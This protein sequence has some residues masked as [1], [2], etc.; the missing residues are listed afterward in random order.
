MNDDNSNAYIRKTISLAAYEIKSRLE[1]GDTAAARLRSLFED[2][3]F[4]LTSIREQATSLIKVLVRTLIDDCRGSIE[5][6]R[7]RV[8]E[9]TNVPPD[10]C[11]RGLSRSRLPA[12]DILVLASH[13]RCTV[14]VD[15]VYSLMGV[16]GVKF[17]AFHAEG[18][19]KALC[20]LLD[21]VVITSNDISVFN[22]AGKDLGSPIRGRSLYPSK[23]SAFSPKNTES[24]LTAKKNDEA[25][26]ASREERH[27]LQDTESRLTLLLRGTMEFVKVTPHKD[28]PV[29][30]I[31]SILG[32]IKVTK[33]IDLQPQLENLSRLLVYLKNTPH[34]EEYKPKTRSWDDGERNK[35]AVGE[36]KNVQSGGNIASRFGIKTP[37]IP[38]M[39][40][41]PQMPQFSAPKLK[42]GGFQSFYGKKNTSKEPEPAS[43]SSNAA[44]ITQPPATTVQEQK[45][46]ETLVGEV[47]AWISKKK[48]IKNVP[49]EFKALFKHLEAEHLDATP[50]GEEESKKIKPSHSDSTICPNP[51][52][53]T[54]SGIEGIFDIQRVIITMPHAEQLHHQVDSA[55]HESE[56]ISGDCTI[57]TG[58]STITVRFSCAAGD[59]RKQLNV[60]DVV[61]QALFDDEVEEGAQGSTQTEQ[62][63]TPGQESTSYYN[64]L[65]SISSGLVRQGS[66][67]TGAT[68]NEDV[69]KDVQ[70]EETQAHASGQ[71]EEQRRVT[72]MLDFVQETD[73]NFIVGE[74]VLARFTGAEGAKWFLCQL[75]L[76]ST[77]NYY[78][79][80]IATDEIDF[81]TVV[82]E[83]GLMGHW[84]N[85]MENKKSELCRVV[86]VFVHARDARRYADEVAGPEKEKKDG[87]A[88]NKTEEEEDSDNAESDPKER[89]M[90]FIK[91]GTHIGA[92]IVQT[93]TDKWGERLDGMLSDTILQKVQKDLRA[94]I[95]N[96]NENK[97]LLPAMFLSGV[98]VHMF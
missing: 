55:V 21:E 41:M 49:D 44:P 79:R 84:K 3:G 25:A 68:E 32:F 97:D 17:P 10:E 51:I 40:Q 2:L 90:D 46:P 11:C 18:P 1:K 78:G 37:Q 36:G 50:A 94:A 72:A 39:P 73:L 66:Q 20:R 53:L 63:L 88:P 74:W 89:L 98:K 34:F 70:S 19:T 14:P 24:Y 29:D 33:L 77:H 26:K 38:Q 12:R 87:E 23:F 71:T 93:V 58:L 42:V 27:A 62:P 80:R 60:C 6:D 5:L 95:V 61:K 96:L 75:E 31:R 16:L 83:S 92:G 81:K 48:D 85:Y 15:S 43:G 7:K 69:K 4:D 52:T 56:K 59:L 86:S 64:K 65:T 82:P 13:R 91:R 54:T 8:S 67:V 57:S 28:V 47:E 45:E 76:G 22:W 35:S 9:F 30:L